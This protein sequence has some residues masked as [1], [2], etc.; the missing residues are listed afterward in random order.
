MT[1]NQ[2]RT[3]QSAMPEKS[4][5]VRAADSSDFDGNLLFAG[6]RFRTGTPF[7]FH[8]ARSGIDQSSHGTKYK[9]VCSLRASL[10]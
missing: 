1:E 8:L 10:Y 9:V 7:Q 4:R 6:L 3:P 5:N 2:R